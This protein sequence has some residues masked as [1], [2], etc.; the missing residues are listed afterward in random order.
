MID[1][2]VYVGDCMGSRSDSDTGYDGC[3]SALQRGEKVSGY[4]STLIP[5]SYGNVVVLELPNQGNQV[6]I[7]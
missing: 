6:I 2:R 3:N 7:R 1:K 5:Y 4:L